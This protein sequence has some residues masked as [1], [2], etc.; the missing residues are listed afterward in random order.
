MML[1][2]T[3]LRSMAHDLR[4]LG[5]TYPLR[6]KISMDEFKWL[7]LYRPMQ[8]PS[9]VWRWDYGDELKASAPP[10]EVGRCEYWALDLDARMP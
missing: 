8:L 6:L 4:A 1:T 5:R 7:A 10:Q 9:A 3:I 2:T